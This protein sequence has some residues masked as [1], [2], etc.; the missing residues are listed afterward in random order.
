MIGVVDWLQ[1]AG[2]TPPPSSTTLSF[3]LQA[4]TSAASVHPT[5]ATSASV[6]TIPAT[7]LTIHTFLTIHKF[8]TIH[9]PRRWLALRLLLRVARLHT[10]SLP[11]ARSL[12][13]SGCSGD[14]VGRLLPRFALELHCVP[15]AAAVAGC[16]PPH[17]VTA[18]RPE[19]EKVWLFGRRSWPLPVSVCPR[20]P[21]R[22]DCCC[23]RLRAST[24]RHCPSPG[25]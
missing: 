14:A 3:K 8:L 16:A 19:P 10:A 20:P 23:C 6:L 15:F 5:S 9:A 7:I 22:A 11:L 24:L 21:P 17:C 13:R 18:P 25:A 4:P 2:A 12:R 1:P